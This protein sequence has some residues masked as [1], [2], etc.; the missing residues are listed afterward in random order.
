VELAVEISAEGEVKLI[1]S[2]KATAKGAIKLK[3]K[4]VEA[5]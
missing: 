4:R 1:A 5:K 3:F 2:A